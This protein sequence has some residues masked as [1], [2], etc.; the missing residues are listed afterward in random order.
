MARGEIRHIGEMKRMRRRHQVI[1]RLD[2]SP[3][4]ACSTSSRTPS[5][6]EDRGRAAD[7]VSSS[8]GCGGIAYE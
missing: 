5:K 8:S 6:G 1:Y 7:P 2:T 3:S 4:D